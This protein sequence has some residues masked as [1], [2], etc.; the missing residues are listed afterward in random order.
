MNITK[1]DL[2]NFRCYSRFSID[3]FSNI[4]II[5]GSNGIGKT[6]IIES[7]Y[8]GSLA[9]TFKSNDD[10]SIIKFNK[11]YSKISIKLYSDFTYKYLDY[12]II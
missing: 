10:L 1:I 8:I 3:K 9:K 11:N 12:Y 5:I 4:N 6:S 7:I 2:V